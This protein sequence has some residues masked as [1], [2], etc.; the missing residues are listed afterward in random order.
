MKLPRLRTILL[1]PVVLFGLVYVTGA[2]M[3]A[4][5]DRVVATLEAPPADHGTMMLMGLSGC[6]WAPA[7]VYAA[8]SIAAAMAAP[9]GVTDCTGRPWRSTSRR[10]GRGS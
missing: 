6:H 3:L 9:S 5:D 1:A 8:T 4:L 7:G 2:V 10:T